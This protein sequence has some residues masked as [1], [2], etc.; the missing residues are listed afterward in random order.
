[1]TFIH[2]P[3]GITVDAESAHDAIELIVDEI[4]VSDECRSNGGP[5]VEVDDIEE[6]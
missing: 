6:A 2:T 4:G 1:M 5:I 3:T